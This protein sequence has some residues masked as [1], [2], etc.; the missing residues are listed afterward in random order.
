[1]YRV[2]IP[3]EVHNEIISLLDYIF[4]FSFSKDI[5]LNIA[6]EIYSKIYSLKIFPHRYPIFHNNYRV[7]VVKKNYK[8]FY[9]TDEIKKEVIIY[10]VLSSK[11]DY[12]DLL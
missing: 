7:M 8:I 6:N 2:N 3:D 5:C 4:R 12:E 1:M 9:E 10:K 11:Q